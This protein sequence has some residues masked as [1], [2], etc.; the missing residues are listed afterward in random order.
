[1]RLKRKG[2][3]TDEFYHRTWYHWS[4]GKAYHGKRQMAEAL[5][6]PYHVDFL[7]WLFA[8]Q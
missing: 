8:A 2:D 7:L 1:M 5:S 3:Y 6:R 4:T